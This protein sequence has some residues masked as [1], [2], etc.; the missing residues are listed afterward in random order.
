MTTSG[1]LD[2]EKEIRKLQKKLDDI[3]KLKARLAKGENLEVNQMQKIDKLDELVA[4]MKKLKSWND[5]Q[6]VLT[7]SEG[8]CL[9]FGDFHPSNMFLIQHFLYGETHCS[10]H[11]VRL[12]PNSFIDNSLFVFR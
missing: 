3:E 10:L 5:S 12:F 4:E 9:S 11:S 8:Q 7:V 6:S 1:G 2:K